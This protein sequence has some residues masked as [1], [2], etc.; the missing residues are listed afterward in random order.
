MG[1]AIPVKRRLGATD[2]RK[3]ACAS[4]DTDQARR[5]L[6]LAAVLDGQS[7]GA[8]ARIGGMDRQTL[9]DWVHA[10]NAKGPNGLI[11]A[12][13]PGRPPKLT[14]AQKEKLRPII[15]AGPDPVKDGVVRWRCVDLKRVIK[16]RF[17]VDLGEIGVG[18]LL[19]ELGFSYVSARP[20]HPEQSPQAIE[21]FKAGWHTSYKLEEPANITMLQLPPKSPELN[22]QENIWQYLR[23]NFL[24]NR[25]FASYEAILDACQ[26]AWCSLT[27][28]AGRIASIGTRDWAIMRQSL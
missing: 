17:D 9:R 25:V 1:M 19:K 20:R 27:A 8:A 11:N 26:H 18:H 4:Q 21:D 14:K 16:D 3:R 24:S 6:A 7:R 12:T 22:A 23:Q 5:L 15:V 2:L 28:E 10:Y 13:S